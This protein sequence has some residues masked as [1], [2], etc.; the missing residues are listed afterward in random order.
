MIFLGLLLT[1]FCI[2]GLASPGAVKR[3]IPVGAW[4]A[5]LIFAL[6]IV[7][8]SGL[9]MCG[10]KTQSKLG[11]GIYI[12]VV[13]ACVIAQVSAFIFVLIKLGYVKTSQENMYKVQD[14]REARR[15]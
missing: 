14:A 13:T 2:Y 7:G 10:A 4:W 3:G 11:L 15:A 6:F 12:L 5:S 9:G 1:G 8:I